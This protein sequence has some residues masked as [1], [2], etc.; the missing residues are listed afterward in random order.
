MVAHFQ[1]LKLDVL[2]D[3]TKALAGIVNLFFIMMA[4]L[5][6]QTDIIEVLMVSV[7]KFQVVA[8]LAAIRLLPKIL[9]ILTKT[10]LWIQMVSLLRLVKGLVIVQLVSHL[11]L[12]R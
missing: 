10:I 12:Q 11:L 4:C 6:A 3:I 8:A 7:N 2:M 5:D 1:L 9:K